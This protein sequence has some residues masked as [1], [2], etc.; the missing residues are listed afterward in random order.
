M[1]SALALLSPHA[2][3]FYIAAFHRKTVRPS[4]S[5]NAGTIL[6]HCAG[7]MY[8]GGHR[9]TIHRDRNADAKN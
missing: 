8:G 3:N 2:F 1:R 6:D 7:G 5:K 9:I 4:N